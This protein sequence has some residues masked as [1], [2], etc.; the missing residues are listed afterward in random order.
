MLLSLSSGREIGDICFYCYLARVAGYGRTPRL[1]LA[2]Y[3]LDTVRVMSDF[4]YLLSGWSETQKKNI[5]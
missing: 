4:S 5:L 3:L 1:S 2:L